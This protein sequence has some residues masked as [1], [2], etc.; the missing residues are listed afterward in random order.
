[1][2]EVKMI[3]YYGF[4]VYYRIEHR[5]DGDVFIFSYRQ[6]V[7]GQ[8]RL[9]YEHPPRRIPELERLLWETEN[10]GIWLDGDG[11]TLLEQ[12]PEEVMDEVFHKFLD[13]SGETTRAVGIERHKSIPELTLGVIIAANRKRLVP[14]ESETTGRERTKDA[15]EDDIRILRCLCRRE[16]CTKWRDVTVQ[17]CSVWLSRES[18]HMQK[19]CA[20]MMKRLLLPFFEMRII[21]DLLGWEGYDPE[22]GSNH[23][24]Q[25]KGLVRSNIL[26]NA[27]SY[28]KCQELLGKFISS[29]GPKIVSGVDMALLLKLTLGLDLEE[30]C[31]L[32]IESFSYLKDFPERLTVRITHLFCK[33]SKGTNYCI[34][35][36]EDPYQRRIL[37]LSHLANQCYTAICAQR[38]LTGATPLVPSKENSRRHM[39]PEDLEKELNKR[40][41]AL[42]AHDGFCV[43]GVQA[44][45]ANA[46]LD[47][48]AEQ[49][50]RTSSCEAEELRFI[51]GKRP[52]IVSAVSY[53][54][55]LNE[56][57]LNKLGALQDRWLNRVIAVETVEHDNTYLHKRGALIE[58][59][60]PVTGNRTQ[61]V[62][63]IDFLERNMEEIPEEG[64]MLELHALHGFSG[65]ILWN[66]NN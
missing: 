56:A 12:L 9:D 26:T 17:R 1:M 57:E 16:G 20:R 51:Q 43:E 33:S 36:I 15:I 27:L 53:A 34:R 21:D 29:A 59:A 39:S 58:W 7:A 5:A 44:P 50:L 66:P 14:R 4:P 62:F 28:G 61:V 10:T 18:V 65:T 64:I 22:T 13:V 25:Y 54:D 32:N 30:L 35:E 52:L 45:T 41:S 23:K 6:L 63:K 55:F 2:S 40:F 47:N 49:E 60:T 37:P 8:L 31:A 46:V 19:A 11:K 24:P 3:T 38:K 48:T 42:F